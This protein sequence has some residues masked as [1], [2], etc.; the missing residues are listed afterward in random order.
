[1]FKHLL[2]AMSWLCLGLGALVVLINWATLVLW[3]RR[4]RRE[5]GHH[6]S[7][8]PLLGLLFPLLSLLFRTLAAASSPRTLLIV[9]VAGLDPS[10]WSL[11]TLPLRQ[12]YA[13]IRGN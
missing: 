1:M 13:A 7:L 8:T 5:P 4:S 11:L 2:L 12:A 3:F 9:A 10:T 6:T